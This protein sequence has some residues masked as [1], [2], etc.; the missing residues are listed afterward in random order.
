VYKTA[1]YARLS[2]LDNGK[3]DGESIENQVKLVKQYIHDRPYLNLTSVYIDNGSTGTNYNRPQFNEMMDAVKSGA[4]NCIVVKDLSRFGRNY[5]ETG[6]Y[7]EKIFPFI[8]VRLIAVNDNYDNADPRSENNLAVAL[9]TLVNDMYAKDISKKITAIVEAK[10]KRGDFIGNYAPYGYQKADDKRRLIIDPVTAPIIRDI[11]RWKTEGVG[12][13]QIARR[14]NEMGVPSPSNYRVGIGILTTTKYQNSL[15][16]QQTIK[17]ILKNP[18]YTGCVSQGK[19]KTRLTQ[20]LATTRISPDE[21][22]NVENMH[23]PIIEKDVFDKVN[24]ILSN[25]NTAYHKNI[26]KHRN[27]DE[28]GNMFKSLLRCGDCGANLIRRKEVRSRQSKPA[29]YYTFICQNYEQN[30]KSTCVGRK[31]L[32]E[33]TLLRVVWESVKTQIEL[34][35][36]LIKLAQRIQERDVYKAKIAN[37]TKQINDIQASIDKLDMRLSSLYNDHSDAILTESEYQYAK[38]KYRVDKDAL[39]RKQKELYAV[40]DNQQLN[41]DLANTLPQ[42]KSASELTSEMLTVLVDYI[43]VSERDT[44]SIVFKYRDEY[45]NLN[46]FVDSENKREAANCG[47]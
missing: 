40:I 25:I 30:R 33:K 38:N 20:G 8:G 6:N 3:Q 35:V 9:K 16:Q 46:N 1:I 47:E 21:W 5:I 26:G 13:T 10:Q 37:H 14:L 7:I 36:D 45:S 34:W 23:E 32:S 31:L 15:W 11:F 18:V 41:N 24:G 17:S 4:V 39:L 28:S 2:L 43:V 27:V 19:Q 12:N 44:V 22:I 42:F 29:A